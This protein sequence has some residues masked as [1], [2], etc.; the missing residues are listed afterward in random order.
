MHNIKQSLASATLVVLHEARENG[1]DCPVDY[2][3]AEGIARA[4]LTHV[5]ETL[6]RLITVDDSPEHNQ[7]VLDCI[8]EF[9]K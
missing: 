6:E 7:A 8:Y 9:E 1:N 3:D 5:K 2:G 4:L